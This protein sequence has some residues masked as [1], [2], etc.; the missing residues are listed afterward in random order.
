MELRPD[1]KSS[2][3]ALMFFLKQGLC[4]KSSIFDPVAF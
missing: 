1:Q 2:F 3:F 4:Q